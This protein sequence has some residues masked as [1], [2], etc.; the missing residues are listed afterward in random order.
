MKARR[1]RK[2][3][4]GES[5]SKRSLSCTAAKRLSQSSS[6]GSASTASLPGVRSWPAVPS[7]ERS[8]VRVAPTT[9]PPTANGD[10]RRTPICADV[11]AAANASRPPATPLATAGGTCAATRRSPA[12]ASAAT[13]I[14]HGTAGDPPRTSMAGQATSKPPARNASHVCTLPRSAPPA[15]LVT[16]AVHNLWRMTRCLLPSRH[17]P[18]APTMAAAS[19][20]KQGTRCGA[21]TS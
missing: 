14:G 4:R 21:R 2:A 10:A 6:A 17:P 15:A 7:E 3:D 19:C 8:N 9:R 16:P 5:F 11:A 13:T 20:P 12:A 1:S 18:Q